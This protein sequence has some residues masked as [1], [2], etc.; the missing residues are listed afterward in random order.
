MWSFFRHLLQPAS[1]KERQLKELL[2]IENDFLDDEV[3]KDEHQLEN[4]N[5][6]LDKDSDSESNETSTVCST[7]KGVI[8]HLTITGGTIDNSIQFNKKI[9]PLFQ[10]LHTG[11]VVEYLVYK[12]DNNVE[13]VVKIGNIIE[14]VWEETTVAKVRP[15]YQGP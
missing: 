3:K 11:C 6:I 4:D 7:Q 1:E 9:A 8:T 2:A 14:H 5:E 13:R 10:D 15:K 12:N